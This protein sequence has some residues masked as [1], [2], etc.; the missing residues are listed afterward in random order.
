MYQSTQAVCYDNSRVYK[1]NSNE[2]KKIKQLMQRT[3]SK[4]PRSICPLNRV[5]R[6][7][8]SN[9]KSIFHSSQKYAYSLPSKYPT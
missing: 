6:R 9:H 3:E 1:L 4:N 2:S 5:E 7:R 8:A